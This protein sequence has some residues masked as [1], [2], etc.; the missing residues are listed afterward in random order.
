MRTLLTVATLVAGIRL[1]IP[2]AMAALGAVL[3]ERAGVLNLGLEGMMLSGALAGYLATKSAGSPWV[4][5]AAGLVV[6]ALCGA[7]MALLVVT[8]RANQIV[9]G[10]AFTLLAAAATTY[11]F[12]RSYA[13]GTLPPRIERIDWP[14]LALLVLAVLAGVWFVL[15]RTTLGLALAAVGEKPEA[16]DALGY[17]VASLRR[18]A[19][20]AGGALAGLGGAML[21]CGPL[22]LFIEG[23]TAGRGWVALALVVFS[24]WRPL[25]AVAGALLFGLCDA[26]Q[27]RLQGTATSVPYEVFLALPYVVTLVALMV[28]ARA[29]RTPAALAV[30]YVR[31]AV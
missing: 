27:L 20:I 22:G 31:G 1:A 4:G 21:V 14:W 10:L 18:S 8:I 29:S 12:Q 28:R 13:I 26:A 7:L 16:V 23:V 19:T 11:V 6:G 3:N 25:P 2:V 30:P 9:T 17:G 15:N 5:L 24:G